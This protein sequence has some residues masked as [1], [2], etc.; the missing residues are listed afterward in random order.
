V[1]LT[2]F[3]DNA[4]ECALVEPLVLPTEV[5]GTWVNFKGGKKIYVI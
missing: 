1:R 2:Y 4:K 5:K 3:A